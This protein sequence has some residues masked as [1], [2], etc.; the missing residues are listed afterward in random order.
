MPNPVQVP[1]IR[2]DQSDCQ[3]ST[4]PNDPDLTVGTVIVQRMDGVVTV[5]VECTL[6][7][8]GQYQFNLKCVQPLGTFPTDGDGIGQAKYS[9]QADLVGDV[10]AFDCY[11]EPPVDGDKYQSVT[12]NLV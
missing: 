2:W 4:V 12:V 6:E 3:N 8:N 5:V 1:L 11:Q 10:F 9:F 7:D